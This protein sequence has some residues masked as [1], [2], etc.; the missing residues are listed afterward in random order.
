MS[1]DNK[2]KNQGF[3]LP[4]AYFAQF[5]ARMEDRKELEKL[6]PGKEGFSVPEE[7]FQDLETDIL[8]RA[9]KGTSYT[10]IPDRVRRF[11]LYAA[12]VLTLV[13]ISTWLANTGRSEFELDRI[14][15]ADIEN[16]LENGELEIP[17]SYLFEQAEISDLGNISMAGDQIDTNTLEEYLLNEMD[18]YQVPE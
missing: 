16:M 17:E 15:S 7:Y 11:S 9:K 13:L 5:E 2:N 12:A 1:L 14:E 6:L 10:A 3:Q 18:I 4:D 8:R